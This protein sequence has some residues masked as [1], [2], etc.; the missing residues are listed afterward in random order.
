MLLGEVNVV[1]PK[2]IVDGKKFKLTRHVESK[3]KESSSC[4]IG[5][6]NEEIH[7]FLRVAQYKTRLLRKLMAQ[8]QRSRARCARLVK[9]YFLCSPL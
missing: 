3:Q 9:Q 6:Q 4:S 8:Q 5:T 1:K 7:H 2:G